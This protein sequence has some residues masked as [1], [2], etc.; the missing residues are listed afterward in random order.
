MNKE[1]KP[2]ISGGFWRC[3]V[4]SSKIV[5]QIVKHGLNGEPVIALKECPYCKRKILWDSVL[6]KG[7][8]DL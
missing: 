5:K 7:W 6:K 4:C 8:R 2:Y 3:N 1:S